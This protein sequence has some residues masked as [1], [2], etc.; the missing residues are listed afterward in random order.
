MSITVPGTSLNAAG[1]PPSSPVANALSYSRTSHLD[2]RP[3]LARTRHDQVTGRCCRREHSVDF[4][5]NA[6]HGRSAR[7]EH[8]RRRPAS[9]AAAPMSL[10]LPNART[11]SPRARTADRRSKRTPTAAWQASNARWLRAMPALARVVRRPRDAGSR[12][13]R[14]GDVPRGRDGIRS[15]LPTRGRS[16]VS[17][18]AT[19][20]RKAGLGLE[21][22]R[23]ARLRS[24]GSVAPN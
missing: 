13:H 15:T 22:D 21:R 8:Q 23:C 4:I 11:Q 17:R 19:G 14:P 6:R 2:K 3:A 18:E 5:G 12:E 20:W 1:L 9:S 10:N 16:A 24:F 7:G